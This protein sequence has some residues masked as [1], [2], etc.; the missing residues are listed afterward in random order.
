MSLIGG[1]SVAFDPL[2][3]SSLATLDHTQLLAAHPQFALVAV[4]Q[5]SVRYAAMSVPSTPPRLASVCS[6]KTPCGSAASDKKFL[7]PYSVAVARLSDAVPTSNCLDIFIV[8][9]SLREAK[10]RSWW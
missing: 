5:S 4:V 8:V 3:E 7:Q 6:F 9:W 2:Y 10:A 1:W